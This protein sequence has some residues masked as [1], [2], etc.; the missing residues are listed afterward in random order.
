MHIFQLGMAMSRS[1]DEDYLNKARIISGEI[2]SGEPGVPE[3]SGV[4]WELLVSKV[5]RR[6]RDTAIQTATLWSTVYFDGEGSLA[7]QTEY[8]KRSKDA[9]LDVEIDFLEIEEYVQPKA[10]LQQLR[11]IL[12]LVT[13][14]VRR[15]K[16]F[17]LRVSTYALMAL[18]LMALGKCRSAPLLE[19]LKL[20]WEGDEDPEE[21]FPW[22]RLKKQDFIIFHGSVP[23]L[24]DLTL[25]GAFLD[26]PKYRGLP[27]LTR[28][29]LHAQ[30]YD[31]R[32]SYD[33]FIR[34]LRESPR[35]ATLAIASSGPSGNWRDWDK[36]P[37]VLPSIEQLELG[38]LRPSEA[39]ALLRRLTMP[40]LKRIMIEFDGSE[41]CNNLLSTLSSPDETTGHSMLSTLERLEISGLDCS[42]KAIEKAYAAASNLRELRLNMLILRST[43]YRYLGREETSTGRVFCP[44]LEKLH[45]FGLTEA[46]AYKLMKAR[47]TKSDPLKELH[48]NTS[49]G[50]L[51]ETR[52]TWLRSAV[53]ELK[54]E[55]MSSMVLPRFEDDGDGPSD[56]SEP[57]TGEDEG[58]EPDGDYDSSDDDES[59]YM[60]GPSVPFTFYDSDI[61]SDS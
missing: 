12:S 10:A 7:R 18:T 19:T 45:I 9:P 47:W 6:W 34:I 58:D 15:W 38:Y 60:D 16:S 46:R 3:E 51:S 43:W 5:C 29:E 17:E 57:S 54:F 44:K 11:E 48:V 26:W 39:N 53:G 36:A 35:L 2:G 14:H 21:P 1:E 28:L 52:A 41:Y 31:V 4:P 20:D 55:P 40:N 32:P 49:G 13:R 50:K 56:E 8:L 24:K 37:V 42:K 33:D 27:N 59:V 22:P 61:E 30:T 23:Q 25:E